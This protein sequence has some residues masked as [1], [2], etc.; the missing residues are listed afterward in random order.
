MRLANAVLLFSV[1]GVN[2]TPQ[3]SHEKGDAAS[4]CGG[5]PQRDVRATELGR[6]LRDIQT[7]LRIPGMSAA[8]VS[9]GR[10]VWAC[11][12]G[13]ADLENHRAATP[14]T[15]Y[16]IASLTK[17]FAAT[18]AM[19]LKEEG[20]LSLDTPI[21]EYARDF[22][23]D[24][25]TVRQIL[26]HTSE[27]PHHRYRYSGQRFWYATRVLEKA[28]RT[29][30]E[31]LLTAR[32]LEPAQMLNTLPGLASTHVPK[33]R[34]EAV[35]RQ[36]AVPY[37]LYGRDEIVRAPYPPSDLNAAAGMVSTVLDLASYE[38]A[39]EENTLL[40]GLA[41][42]EMLQPVLSD[43]GVVQPYAL[44][45]FVQ[46]SHGVQVVWHHGSLP[47]FSSLIV[48]VPAR[49][50][51]FIL[52]ANSD[53]VSHPFPKME[54]D[55]DVM[56]SAFATAFLRAY[57]FRDATGKAGPIRWNVSADSFERELRKKRHLSPDYAYQREAGDY[58]AMSAW[59]AKHRQEERHAIFVDPN[60]LRQ[61][62]GRYQFDDGY[63]VSILNRGGTLWNQG[64]GEEL[65]QLFP[66]AKDQ[67]FLKVADVQITF[68]RNGSDSVAAL[69]TKQDGQSYR[70][71]RV[72]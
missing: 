42:R 65:I 3:S 27:D 15:E 43:A 54:A 52:L 24:S 55:G 7:L 68:E 31:D 61:F 56:Q 33:P 34:S 19:Q 62:V 32:I 22:K 45:W 6:E 25:I 38:R 17:P 69:V 53:G 60:A 40:S 36:L 49:R 41:N 46:R 37:V 64:P 13:L 50:L 58:Q 21:R 14:R 47:A 72:P 1:N 28:S 51:A 18:L 57:V 9:K 35:R 23:N 16:P 71:K 10:I 67:F 44:G 8:V 29:T 48:R 30:M 11:G 5:A 4:N 2:W 70:A 26:S 66:S 63:T 59:L 20:L 12:Y 39:I